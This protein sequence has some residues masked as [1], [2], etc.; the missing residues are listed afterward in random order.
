MAFLPKTA[1]F[2]SSFYSVWINSWNDLFFTLFYVSRRKY[3]LRANF[4]FLFLMDLRFGMSWTRLDYFWKM[5]V[6]VFLYMCDKNF[7]AS[8]AQELMNRISWKFIFR[9]I[10]TLIS[11]WTFGG[12]HWTD[13]AAIKRFPD[14]S[15]CTDLGFYWMKLHKIYIQDI[16]Y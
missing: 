13:G 12:N 6:S 14:L 16:Y 2:F 8:V 3:W 10:P 5:S 7:G 11:V 4:R 9:I 1:V 15:G